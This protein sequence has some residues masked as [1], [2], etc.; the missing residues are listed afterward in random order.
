MLARTVSVS[1]ASGGAKVSSFVRFDDF[2]PSNI[3]LQCNVTGTVSY[4]VETSLDDPNDPINPVAFG[5]MTWVSSSDTAVVNA[6]ATAQSNFLFAPKFARV[7][8]NS[9]AGS[10]TATF[11]QSSNGPK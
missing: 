9:G 7:R 1:D 6:T 4:T 2:A 10:V 11:L 5:S 3:S 8:L